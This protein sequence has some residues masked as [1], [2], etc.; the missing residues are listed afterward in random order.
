MSG[1]ESILRAN[2][3]TAKWNEK[4]GQYYAKFKGD[5]GTYKIWLEEET[6]IKKKLEVVTSNKVAGTAFWKLGFERAA[7]WLT[8]EDALK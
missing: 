1:A 7:T 3:V 8:I 2:D 6:S 5:N 4:T